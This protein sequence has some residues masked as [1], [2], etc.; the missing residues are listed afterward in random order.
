MDARTI[1]R[2]HALGRAGIG[3]ALC[4]APG[5]AARAWIGAAA[6]APAAKVLTTGL[7]GRDLA[8]GLGAARAL[9]GSGTGGDGEDAG[10]V[11]ARPWIQAGM[12]AD[13][14]DLLT[15]LLH[16]RDLSVPAVAGISAMAGGSVALAAWLL[17]ALPADAPGP[18]AHGS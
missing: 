4:A 1:A 5:L 7:G 17:R 16:R 10:S 2:L 14:A 15:T 3:A 12:V 18:V 11:P 9:R 6:T 8:I 13:T